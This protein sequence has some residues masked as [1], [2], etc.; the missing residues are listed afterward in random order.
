M[1]VA[2]T[3]KNLFCFYFELKETRLLPFYVGITNTTM[4][5]SKEILT[6]TE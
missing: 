4:L 1:Q 5:T 2:S 3:K 6:K